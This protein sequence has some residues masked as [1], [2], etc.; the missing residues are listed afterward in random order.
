MGKGESSKRLKEI[1]SILSKH[2]IISG[3]TPE[4]LKSI[5]EELGPTCIK[6]GQILSM[7]PNILPQS[8]ARS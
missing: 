3:M 1:V 8:T 4:N 7:Q 6:A 2:N 5:F